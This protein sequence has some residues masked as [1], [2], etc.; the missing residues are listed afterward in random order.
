M[1]KCDSPEKF[2]SQLTDNF[3][4]LVQMMIFSILLKSKNDS[5]DLKIEYR[6]M[7]GSPYMDLVERMSNKD[8]AKWFGLAQH[9]K[10]GGTWP[11]GAMLIYLVSTI[12]S[13]SITMS[14]IYGHVFHD[15]LLT[16]ALLELYIYRYTVLPRNGQYY[17]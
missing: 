6:K 5:S 7:L 2:T 4:A 17:E 15:A 16:I 12:I 11:R 1:N 9:K 3:C 13:N 14:L 8:Y 10:V